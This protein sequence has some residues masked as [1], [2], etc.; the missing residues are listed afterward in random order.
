MSKRDVLDN[1]PRCGQEN[2]EKHNFCPNCGSRLTAPPRTERRIKRESAQRKRWEWAILAAVVAVTVI[3]YNVIRTAQAST[4]PVKPASQQSTSATQVLSGN[5]SFTQIVADG[6][7][8]MDQQMYSQAITQYEKALSIDS[9]HPDVLV[10]LGACY[11]YLGE[12]KEAELQSLRA[13]QQ[14]PNHDVAHYNMGVIK[15]TQGDFVAAKKWWIQFLQIVGDDDPR[16]ASV[17]EQLQK[18]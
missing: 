9:L 15:F 5:R 12:D 4:E 16:A 3:V 2:T 7:K 10:D 11:H 1:C 17:R 13:L 6:N 18:M 14:D 8:F